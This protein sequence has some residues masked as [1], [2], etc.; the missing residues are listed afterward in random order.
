MST[1]PTAASRGSIS[2]IVFAGIA[3]LGPI[4]LIALY[5]VWGPSA[6]PTGN[7]GWGVLAIVV[8]F[9]LE[10]AIGPIAALFALVLALVNR[11][12]GPVSRRNSTIALTIL[13]ASVSL[14]IIQVLL[15]LPH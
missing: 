13:G 10:V 3:A 11:K 5:V 1:P 14:A 7:N 9:V 12:R 4:V 8:A 2:S 15:Y 6:V